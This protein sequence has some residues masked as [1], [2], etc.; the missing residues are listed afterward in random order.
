MTIVSILLILVPIGFSTK[1]I[2]GAWVHNYMG[3]IFYPMFWFFLILFFYPQFPPVKLASTVFVFSTAIEF[4]QLLSSPL[5]TQIR[6]TFI[7]RTL[8]GTGFVPVDI[9][10]YFIGCIF[11][12]CLHRILYLF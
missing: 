12:I 10:Y 9:F 8:I 6:S 5:L 4:T 1:F 7:G 3:D 11:A 2:G